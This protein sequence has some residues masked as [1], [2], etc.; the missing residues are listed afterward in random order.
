MYQV[1]LRNIKIK[2]IPV[3]EAITDN[4]TLIPSLKNS[5]KPKEVIEM[6][7]KDTQKRRHMIDIFFTTKENKIT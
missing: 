6:L 2:H 5:N 7:I 4:L 3:S 1:I